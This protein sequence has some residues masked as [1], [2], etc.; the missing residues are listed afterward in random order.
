MQVDKR[1][2]YNLWMT[3]A[4]V[5][6]FHDGIYLIFSQFIG[7]IVAIFY[8]NDL[9]QNNLRESVIKMKPQ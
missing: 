3:M 5:G 1:V 4:D 7:P 6:G 2:R 9:L 8:E